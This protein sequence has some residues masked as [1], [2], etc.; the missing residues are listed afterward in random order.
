MYIRKND[1]VLIIRG[2]DRGKKGKVH[3]CLPRENRLLVEGINMRKRH[4]KPRA[5]IRQA[6]IIELE[7]PIHISKVMLVCSKCHEPT[8]V[9]YQ[10][11]DDR[12]KVRVCRECGEVID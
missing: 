1:E 5:N 7:A 12:S 4:M 3:R 9:G 2:D 8:R 11:L 10:I 6:G